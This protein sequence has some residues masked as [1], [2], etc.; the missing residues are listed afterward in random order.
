MLLKKT[1]KKTPKSAEKAVVPAPEKA[2][3]LEV[4]AKPRTSRSSK[5]KKIEG[6]EMTSG[7][8]LHKSASPALAPEPIVL[9]EVTTAPPSTRIESKPIQDVASR[10]IH[11]H[12]IAELAYSYWVTR[13]HHHGSA[14]E[15]WLRAERE[16]A[17][18]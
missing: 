2:A 18:L 12:Q 6:A 1:S 3:E 14:E 17:G 4:A 13:G 7:K 11:A 8:H 15:D 9:N 10:T 16:L 5:A